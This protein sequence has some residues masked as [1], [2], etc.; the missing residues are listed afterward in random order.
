MIERGIFE[1]VLVVSPHTDDGEF[2]MGGTIARLVESG[3][4]LF[5]IAFSTAEKSV[6]EGYPPNILEIEVREATKRLGIPPD[7]LFI[8]KYEVRKLNYVRQEI[9]EILVKLR[10]EINPT[11]VFMPSPNDVHQD[12]Q[13]VSMECMRAFKT[14]TLMGYE[15]PWNNFKF[16]NQVFFSLE[17]RHVDKKIFAIEAYS[18][19]RFRSYSDPEFIRSLARVR[20]VQVGVEFAEVFELIR[21]VLR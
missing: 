8:Y 17:K 15:L 18:S 9:L 16:N 14:S 2:G 4:E 13:T 11:V 6:P 1:K 21:M 12:H 7:N 5:Y 3:S 19:Q 10:K 20:G